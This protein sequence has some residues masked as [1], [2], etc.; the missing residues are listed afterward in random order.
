MHPS[1][2][3]GGYPKLSFE[4]IAKKLGVNFRKAK[5]GKVW[6]KE[7]REVLSESEHMARGHSKSILAGTQCVPAKLGQ[8][9]GKESASNTGF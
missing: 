4:E 5:N 9:L 8:D 7:C 3:P 6:E 1:G 2:R